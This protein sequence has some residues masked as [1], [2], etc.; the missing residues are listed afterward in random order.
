M[1]PASEPTPPRSSGVTDDEAWEMVDAH[2]PLIWR[3][4]DAGMHRLN[5]PHEQRRDL[6]H[7]AK[8]LAHKLAKRHDPTRGEFPHYLARTL[9]LELRYDLTHATDAMDRPGEAPA[10]VAVNAVAPARA[11]ES[12]SLQ[13]RIAKLRGADSAIARMA[14]FEHCSI[15]IIARRTGRSRHWLQNRLVF[16]ERVLGMS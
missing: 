12:L 16:L 13:E 15:G 4:V 6:I 8:I 2:L 1:I 3:L 14:F 9:S 11:V 5:I 7:N 10:V